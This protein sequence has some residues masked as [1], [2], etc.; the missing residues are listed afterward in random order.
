[1]ADDILPRKTRSVPHLAHSMHC[2]PVMSDTPQPL[3]EPPA[4]LQAPV[5]ITGFLCLAAIS[6]VTIG[7]A[8][9][10]TQLYAIHIGA[11]AFEIGIIGAME[12][13]GMMLLTVPAGFI[14]AR[15]GARIVYAIAS[16]GPFLLYA[17]APWLGQWWM[18]A[19]V[20]LLVG[21]CIPFR[22]VSMASAFLGQLKRIGTQ[23]AGWYRAALTFGMAVLGPAT[24]TFV[25]GRF[26]YMASFL[27]IAFLFGVMAA[28]SLSF[29][30]PREEQAPTDAVTAP[31]SPSFLGQISHLFRNPDISESCALEFMSGATASLFAT[32]ILLV[33]LSLPGLGAEDGVTV[34]LVDGL[35]TISALFLGAR[36]ITRLS[37]RQAYAIGLLLAIAAMTVT[38]L[39]NGLGMLILAGILLSLGAATVHLVNMML[40]AHLPGE[41]S[42]VSSVYQLSQMLGSVTGA[43]GGGLLSKFMPLQLVFLAWTLFLLAGAVPIWRFGR[44]S[45][46][47]SPH[48]FPQEAKHVP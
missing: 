9:I 32:F 41:K 18:L 23:K 22:T 40:L 46:L 33:A 37:R 19:L 31:A 13:I 35:V 48:I 2:L 16:L 28:F 10:V 29:F 43:I 17:L 6:G 44:R 24:A 3:A 20:R 5:S 47:I 7:M 42:K 34:L 30:P 38:S 25:T 21:I 15:H 12:A 14:I 8:N 26:S 4:S 11:S 45:S 1:M 39:A 36:L 27:L